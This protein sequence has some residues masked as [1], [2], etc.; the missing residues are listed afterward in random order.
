MGANVTRR[1]LRVYGALSELKGSDADVLDALIP[2][3]EPILSVMNGRVFDPHVFSAGVRKLYRWR[4]TGDIAATFIPRLERKGFLKKEASANQKAVWSV[5]YKQDAE[6][7]PASAVITA[8][9]QIIDEFTK[10]SPRLTDL[11]SYKRSRDELKD[12]LIRFLVTMDAHGAGAYAPELG[13]F[14]P[15]GEAGRLLSQLAEGGTPL[16]DDDKYMCARF[17]QDLMKRRPEFVPH[18]VRLASIALLTEVIE[19]FIKPTHVEAKTDLVVVLDAPIALDL[20]GC[21]GKALRDDVATIVTALKK[22]GASFIVFPT[23]C[24]EM[25]RNLRSML[26]LSKEERRGYTHNAM[27]KGE[28]ANDFVTAVANNPEAALERIGIAV[29]SVN[30][31]SF[32]GAHKY[33]SNAQ[34]DD[35]LNSIWWGNHINAKEHDATCAALIMRLRDGRH[36]SD[37]FKCRYVMATRNGNF[38]NHARSYCLTSRMINETQEG[39]I[40]HQREL[41]TVAWLR[42][43]LGGDETI[44]RGHLVATCDRVL[45]VRPEVRAAVAAQLTR[46]TPDR[47]EQF[48]LLMQDARSVRKLADQTLNNESVVTSENAEQLLNVMRLATAEE[49]QERH[50]AEMRAK[51]AASA[52]EIEKASSEI[53]SLSKEVSDLKNQQAEVFALKELQLKSVVAAVN[54]VCQRTEIVAAIILAA[55]GVC[56]II[57]Q[58]TG[59]FATY[60]VW[61]V[62]SFIGGVLG[63]IRLGFAI[64]ERPMP[65]LAT[66]LNGFCRRVTRRKFASLGLDIEMARLEYKSGRVYLAEKELLPR[67]RSA[68]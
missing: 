48:N 38:V 3:F 52:I 1:A 31:D 53:E 37:V 19:D 68:Q 13:L 17:V 20:L 8:F 57:N 44:P 34:F 25:Q 45:Q 29:R 18:L 12:I 50:E 35:F 24:V 62:L 54:K 11:L 40:I 4:F 49:L 67:L 9:E 56:A 41:A 66:L 15:G 28:V 43:G 36:S 64:F 33:F 14:E 55:I 6:S 23:S 21:S 7:E 61:T 22:I 39:P 26:S 58:L 30:L 60:W 51:Q 27:I 16:N 63:F 10:F 32:P 46:I 2:F 65:A 59:Y 5:Q 47:L 42:T